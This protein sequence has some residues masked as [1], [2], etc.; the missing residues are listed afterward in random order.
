[1]YNSFNLDKELTKVDPVAALTSGIITKEDIGK[2][3]YLSNSV[4][5]CQEW[6]I[7]G[8]NHD[9]TEDTVDLWPKYALNSN[10]SNGDILFGGYGYCGSNIRA[11]LNCTIYNGF[12][13]QIRNAMQVQSFSDSLLI[14]DKVKIP[15]LMEVGLSGISTTVVS[16]TP[17][18]LLDRKSVV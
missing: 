5:T 7:A 6:R 18:E 10:G 13:T 14:T 3:V 17:Y 1:M 12:S 8:I 16:G 9:G 15:S 4:C 11:L 2:T